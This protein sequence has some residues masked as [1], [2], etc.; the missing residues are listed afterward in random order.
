MIG[1]IMTHDTIVLKARNIACRVLVPSAG[2][3]VVRAK[4]EPLLGRKQL[5]LDFFKRT[6]EQAKGEQRRIVSA[7]AARPAAHWGTFRLS[8]LGSPQ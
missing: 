3:N 7:M 6:F 4:L 1:A 8:P 2:Q 5:E